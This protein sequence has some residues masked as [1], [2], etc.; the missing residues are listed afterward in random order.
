MC[1]LVPI[2]CTPKGF[3]RVDGVK[4]V[5]G[6]IALL[7]IEIGLAEGLITEAIIKGDA[8]RD[9]VLYLEVVIASE[10]MSWIN[11]LTSIRAAGN[12]ILLL[13]LFMEAVFKDIISIDLHVECS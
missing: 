8:S 11:S 2:L 1:N 10:E 9:N 5:R 7:S 12:S 4:L 3:A 13:E 6:L